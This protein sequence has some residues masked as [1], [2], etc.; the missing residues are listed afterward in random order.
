MSSEYVTSTFSVGSSHV[1]PRESRKS[2]KG[3]LERSRA[4]ASN[5]F[6]V[7]S[8]RPHSTIP[9]K[10]SRRPRRSPIRMPAN[11]DGRPR[12]PP[13]ANRRSSYAE[14]GPGPWRAGHRSPEMRCAERERDV[15]EN[16][17]E[18]IYVSRHALS[19]LLVVVSESALIA[20]RPPKVLPAP[21]SRLLGRLAH[22]QGHSTMRDAKRLHRAIRNGGT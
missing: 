9:R 20:M 5:A 3:E 2:G 16:G 4:W 6:A 19:S 15:V 12:I 18:A 13:I 7:R 11:V 22:A 10:S 17:P 8:P 14:A 21:R 1:T